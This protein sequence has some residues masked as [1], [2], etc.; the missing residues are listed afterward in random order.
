MVNFLASSVHVV[1]R[2]LESRL[3]QTIDYKIVICCFSSTHASLKRAKTV[4]LGIRI[5]CPKGTTCLS[6]DCCF[7]EL[8]L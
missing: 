7:S 2:E 8:A 3:D 4:W 6:A 1:D 5:M